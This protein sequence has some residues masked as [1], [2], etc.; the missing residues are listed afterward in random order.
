MKMMMEEVRSKEANPEI[1]NSWR[2][3]KIKYH[4]KSLFEKID[5]LKKQSAII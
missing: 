2:I 5:S 3:K 1:G 4:S